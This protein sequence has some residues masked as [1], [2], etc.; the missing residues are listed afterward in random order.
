[1]EE[2]VD[3]GAEERNRVLRTAY[4]Q[5]LFDLVTEAVKNSAYTYSEYMKPSE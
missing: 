1:M 4:K 2:F 3:I 5:Y